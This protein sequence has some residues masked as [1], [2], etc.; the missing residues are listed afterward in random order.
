MAE[1]NDDEAGLAGLRILVAEDNPANRRL[2]QAILE[3]AGAVVETVEDGVDAL[4][5]LR[6]PGVDL[7]LM[8]LRMPRMGG[9][10]T[11]HR[12]RA[13]E[14]GASDLPVVALT[15]DDEQDVA[16]GFDAIQ[17]KPI[18]AAALIAALAALRPSR[19]A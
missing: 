16:D 5:R 10:E 13:G 6:E 4:A 9:A 12:I 7:V 2:V 14:A 1:H 18:Q 11:L 17:P 15:A 3:S 19:A 8:D